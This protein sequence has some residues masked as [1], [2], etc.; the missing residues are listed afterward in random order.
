MRNALLAILA[1]LLILPVAART[2]RH[3]RSVNINISTDDDDEITSCDQIRVRFDGEA[4]VMREEVLPAGNVRSLRGQASTHGGI[5]VTG[6]DRPDWS[7][8]ACVASASG[9]EGSSRMRPYLRGTE[10]GVEGNDDDDR[11]V[12]YFLIRAPRNAVLDLEAHNGA[13]GIQGISGSLTARTENGP[14]TLT[15]VSG[16]VNATA[17]NGPIDFAGSA[18]KVRLAAQNGPVTVKLTGSS[19]TGGNLDA[20]TENGPICLRIPRDY[21]SGVVV[22]SDGHGPISC[23]AEACRQAKRT[24]GND[25]DSWNDDGSFRRIELGSG[26]QIV[27]MSTNNGPVTVKEGT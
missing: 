1:L 14:I 8:K 10:L 16:T 12:I 19:W 3:S 13:L 6:W 4:A 25:D 24:W 15:S 26:A 18:G 7:V 21:R 17:Q 9:F 23:R 2:N 11:S 22:E 20:S 5:R 27:K